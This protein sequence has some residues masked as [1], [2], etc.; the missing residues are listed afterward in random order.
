MPAPSFQLNILE[1]ICDWFDSK[2]EELNKILAFAGYELT[3]RG[4]VQTCTP[5]QTL[6]DAQ[7]RATPRWEGNTEIDIKVVGETGL[8]ILEAIIA[9]Q[10]DPKQLAA[11]CL[12]TALCRT[13]SRDQEGQAAG[14]A[15]RA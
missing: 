7:R 1:R 2:R 6:T 15:G 14:R 9:G 4:T 13:R 10:R 11:L 3:D 8:H 12:L 5:A